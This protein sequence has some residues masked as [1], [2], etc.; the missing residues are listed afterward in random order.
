MHFFSILSNNNNEPNNDAPNA[1]ADLPLARYVDVSANYTLA[2]TP[3]DYIDLRENQRLVCIGDVHGDL[4][5][6]RDFLE[7]AGVYDRATDSWC[8]GDTIAVQCGDILD[9]GLDELACYRLLSRLSQEAPAHHGK[10]ILLVG[11][12]EALNAMGLFQY[13]PSDL[14]HEQT[15]GRAV[16]DVL[17]TQNLWRKQYANNQPARWASYEPGG[18][19]AHSLLR[20]MK[21]AVRVGKTVCVHAGLLPEHLTSHGGIEGMNAAFRDWISLGDDVGVHHEDV[22]REPIHNP[23]VYNHHGTYPANTP[24]QPWIDAEK[25]Q[26]FYVN[27]IPPFLQAKPN[28]PGPIWMRDYSS[29]HDVPPL[30]DAQ[31]SLSR[32]LGTTLALLGADRMV[33][34]HTIQHRINGVMD[35]R[36][37]RI[38]VGASR[39]CLGG[40]TEVLEVL[41]VRD[42]GGDTSVLA[43][44][45]SI[46]VPPLSDPPPNDAATSATSVTGVTSATAAPT[47]YRIPASDRLV[48][49]YTQAAVQM[50]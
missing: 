2:H 23:V 15:I 50:F 7:V 48:D 39:G 38:D 45:V 32:A 6:L 40:T 12:H 34:G 9:R 33:V 30:D 14:E 25:R 26:R 13:A 47:C 28:D 24:R 3:E 49:A 31:Q 1:N 4:E 11:N 43:E 5:A 17:G 10:V 8:G 37:W 27:T 36:A 20:N 35:G 41:C 19:L 42:G 29:P 46:R 16:D 21:V 44:E 22:P 18:L